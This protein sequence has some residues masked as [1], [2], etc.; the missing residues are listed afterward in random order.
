[1]LWRLPLLATSRNSDLFISILDDAPAPR[2]LSSGYV[3]TLEHIHLPISELNIEFVHIGL[4]RPMQNGHVESLHGMLRDQCLKA[5]WFANL[6][7]GRR[8]IAAQR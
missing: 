4:G 6:F 2:V 7:K 5:S 3:V 1:L 8:K